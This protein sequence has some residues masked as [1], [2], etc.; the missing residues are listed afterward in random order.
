[1]REPVCPCVGFIEWSSLL[2]RR[3]KG[4]LPALSG[5]AQLLIQALVLSI[6]C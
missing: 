6:V 2:I 3:S 4:N 1:M 5:I